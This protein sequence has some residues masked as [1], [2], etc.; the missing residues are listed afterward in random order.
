M[1]SKVA[2]LCA[3][4]AEM[5]GGAVGRDDLIMRQ[6]DPK[7]LH[8]TSPLPSFNEKIPNVIRLLRSGDGSK[9]IL[10]CILF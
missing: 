3:R 8:P 7:V 5:H 1:C 9:K 2:M 6:V 4:E 10:G